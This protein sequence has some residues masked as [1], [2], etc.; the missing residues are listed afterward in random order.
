M[1]ACPVETYADFGNGDF[2]NDD[3]TFVNDLVC[4]ANTQVGSVHSHGSC[5]FKHSYIIVYLLC[6]LIRQ[7]VID[8]CRNLLI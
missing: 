5:H 8:Q 3:V 1:R 4:F 7:M 6:L 2:D